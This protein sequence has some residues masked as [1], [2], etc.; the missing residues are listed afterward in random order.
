MQCKLL[1]HTESILRSATVFNRWQDLQEGN[2]AGMVQPCS[3]M[4][5]RLH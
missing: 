4:C 2:S 3:K 1:Y 5:L